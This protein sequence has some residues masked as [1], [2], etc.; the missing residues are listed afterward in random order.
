MSKQPLEGFLGV[1][2]RGWKRRHQGADRLGQ[3]VHDPI[4]DTLAKSE[5]VPG[6]QNVAKDDGDSGEDSYAKETKDVLP[7]WRP[8]LHGKRMT[9]LS[10]CSPDRCF[11]LQE[12]GRMTK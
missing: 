7:N 9:N 6:E 1:G 10:E 4:D 2:F 8:F 11:N 12:A 3:N 5:V